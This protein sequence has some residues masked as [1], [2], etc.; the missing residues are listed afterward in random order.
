MKPTR[1]FASVLL[2]LPLALLV[3]AP[4]AAQDWSGYLLI[5]DQ[6]EDPIEGSYAYPNG[7]A[8]AM[9]VTEFHHLV[10][11]DEGTTQP[12]HKPWIVTKLLDKASSRLL[13]A[14]VEDEELTVILKLY[15]Q[16]QLLFEVE[17][18]RARLVAIEPI[19]ESTAT[20]VQQLEKLRFIYVKMTIRDVAGGTLS[21]WNLSGWPV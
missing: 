19:T 1:L 11:T 20:Q 5:N 9:R 3:A 4:A 21:V 18:E 2:T 7:P 6:A 12:Y 8:I 15:Q 17:L 14:F 10:T 16:N 13:Q